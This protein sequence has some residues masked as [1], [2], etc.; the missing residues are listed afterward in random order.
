MKY[1]IIF[2]SFLIATNNTNAGQIQNAAKIL[3]DANCELGIYW[4][5]KDGRSKGQV[6]GRGYCAQTFTEKLSGKSYCWLRTV[7][8]QKEVFMKKRISAYNAHRENNTTCNSE[9]LLKIINKPFV[10]GVFKTKNGI[11][12]LHI[13]PDKH[14]ISTKLNKMFQPSQ[15]SKKNTSN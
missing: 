6:S 13:S 12:H 11:G 14:S 4:A 1:L 3:S 9:S 2:I 5:Y 7:D 15:T 8:L 10:K